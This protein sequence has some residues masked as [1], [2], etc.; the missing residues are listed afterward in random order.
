MLPTFRLAW[1]GRNDLQYVISAGR[2]FLNTNATICRPTLK[3]P[4]A[5]M[6]KVDLG[7]GLYPNATVFLQPNLV[8]GKVMVGLRG[9]ISINYYETELK[10]VSV[11]DAIS[12]RFGLG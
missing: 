9:G 4:V 12:C 10:R 5:S 11:T 6:L 8:F 1:G 3:I 7:V 2:D